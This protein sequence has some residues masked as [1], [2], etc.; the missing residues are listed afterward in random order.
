MTKKTNDMVNEKMIF[1]KK[2]EL[3]V[4]DNDMLPPSSDV[5]NALRKAS[6]QRRDKIHQ[7]VNDNESNY[8][9]NT[10]T[11]K[12][13]QKSLQKQHQKQGE[14]RRQEKE[15]RDK[16]AEEVRAADLKLFMPNKGFETK[17]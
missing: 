12:R 7:S 11:S 4:V 5:T 14:K 8:S 17:P 1:E 15:Q 6:H 10:S 9:K 2:K 13:S 16:E 3:V